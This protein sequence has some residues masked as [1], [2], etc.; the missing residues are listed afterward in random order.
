MYILFWVSLAV[1]VWA[2]LHMFVEFIFTACILI[3]RPK[4]DCYW[5]FS[6]NIPLVAITAAVTLY[7][8]AYNFG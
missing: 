5:D 3:G 8:Y 6:L 1:F 7:L 2:A 4:S